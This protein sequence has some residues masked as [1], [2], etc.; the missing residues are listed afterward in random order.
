MKMKKK[1]LMLVV[2]VFLLCGC[3]NTLICEKETEKEIDKVK[4]KFKQGMPISLSWKRTLIYQDGDAL[5]EM[6]FY[7]EKDYY[8]KYNNTEGLT[9]KIDKKDRKGKIL[10]NVDVDYSKYDIS[11]DIKLPS[12]YID[13]K[14]NKFYLENNGYKC[15]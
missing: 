5:I 2:F 6:N 10:I 1:L 3:N 8:G 9:Y 13:K 14:N 11:T 4:I 15:K 7:E 12:I